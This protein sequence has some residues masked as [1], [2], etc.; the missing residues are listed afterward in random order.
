MASLGNSKLNYA[1]VGQVPDDR[2][3]AAGCRGPFVLLRDC[4]ADQHRDE[5]ALVNMGGP[6]RSKATMLNISTFSCL[7][8]GS[9]VRVACSP[10]A[11]AVPGSIPGA[12]QFNNF[13][14]QS[15]PLLPWTLGFFCVCLSCTVFSV[16][17]SFGTKP[18]V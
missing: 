4:L 5:L 15:P 13:L 1:A 6:V 3:D 9:G 18:S 11:T 16:P 14:L 12:S 10:T 2:V 8:S 7:G 17:L